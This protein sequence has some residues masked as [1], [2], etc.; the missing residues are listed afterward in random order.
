MIKYRWIIVQ[1]TVDALF[2]YSKAKLFPTEDIAP[3]CNFA[4]QNISIFK[5]CSVFNFKI[6]CI[7]TKV[8][9]LLN[10]RIRWAKRPANPIIIRFDS[11]LM[12]GK[13]RKCVQQHPKFLA[14]ELI[15]MRAQRTWY[16]ISVSF[17]TLLNAY[18]QYVRIKYPMGCD[19]C[20]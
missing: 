4:Q 6:S 10:L 15:E 16:P 20:V 12:N 19:I 8:C 2:R 5:W 1:S 17:H 18:T 11:L 9:D 7:F 14:A 13:R 3:P